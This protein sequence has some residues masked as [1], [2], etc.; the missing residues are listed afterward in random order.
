MHY[1]I[2]K[3][4]TFEFFPSS[5]LF[6]CKINQQNQTN[7]SKSTRVWIS[8]P[9]WRCRLSQ[10]KQAEGSHQGASYFDPCVRHPPALKQICPHTETLCAHWDK[11]SEAEKEL[12]LWTLLGLVLRSRSKFWIMVIST[13]KAAGLLLLFLLH[14]CLANHGTFSWLC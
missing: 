13:F 5:A 3:E 12:R 2:I 14:G 8:C 1:W 4:E 7:T 9:L 10:G 6:V 11:H